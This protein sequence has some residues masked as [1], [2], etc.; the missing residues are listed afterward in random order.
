MCGNAK[1]N[2]LLINPEELK[3][4][5]KLEAVVLMIR[6]EPI[7]SKLIPDYQIDWQINNEEVPLN[8]RQEVNKKIYEI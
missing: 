1:A 2:A 6:E 4:L 3:V 7:R 8:K 5:N